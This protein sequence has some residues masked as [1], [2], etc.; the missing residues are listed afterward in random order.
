MMEA[1]ECCS[2]SERYDVTESRRLGLELLPSGRWL[3]A[4]YL[5]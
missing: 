4:V 2:T 1:K 5:F 3:L